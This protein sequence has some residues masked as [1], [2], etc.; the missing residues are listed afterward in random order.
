MQNIALIETHIKLMA[1]PFVEVAKISKHNVPD[2]ALYRKRSPLLKIIYLVII[3]YCRELDI[4][5]ELVEKFKQ[6]FSRK[7]IVFEKF[8]VVGI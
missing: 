2:A 6:I 4:I 8:A 5:I 1:H 3:D 7:C